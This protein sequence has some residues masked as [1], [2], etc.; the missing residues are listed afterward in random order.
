MRKTKNILALII[1]FSLLCVPILSLASYDYSLINPYEF[2]L[3]F[4]D[5]GSPSIAADWYPWG[6]GFLF[7][8]KVLECA[9]LIDDATGLYKTDFTGWI[10]LNHNHR[11]GL[12]KGKIVYE[13][14]FMQEN[15]RGTEGADGFNSL[16]LGNWKMPFK[17]YDATG[18]T[19]TLTGVLLIHAADNDTQYGV[20]VCKDSSLPEKFDTDQLITMAD[21]GTWYSMRIEV[22]MNK[23]T[24]NYYVS[25]EGIDGYIAEMTDVS[26]TGSKSF[27]AAS[28]YMGDLNVQNTDTKLSLKNWKCTVEQID[29]KE[30][31]VKEVEDKVVATALVANDTAYVDYVESPTLVIVTY[32]SLGRLY[33]IASE[34]FTEN[35]DGLDLRLQ[36]RSSTTKLPAN[37]DYK[38]L[39][40]ELNKPKG[41]YT[42]KAYLV[43]DFDSLLP[44]TAPAEL[45]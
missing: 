24:A 9:P 44:Y 30:V 11:P 29:V 19:G 25:Q 37:T 32:D 15:L 12:V 31:N 28:P 17:G 4:L 35:N 43:S 36:K 40:V 39:K 14:D 8:N 34:K 5:S 38:E 18:A 10:R 7:N 21:F 1:V 33:D 26:L 45:N 42:A 20:V 6:K 3:N 27:I 41:S 22:N 16:S 13:F 2:A 23:G